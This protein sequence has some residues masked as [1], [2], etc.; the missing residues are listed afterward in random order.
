MRFLL[1]LFVCTFVTL[2]RANGPMDD[3]HKCDNTREA[4]EQCAAYLFDKDHD[5]RITA[6]EIDTVVPDLVSLPMT[7]GFNST[8]FM[9]CDI[10][11][12]GALTH[13][14]WVHPNATACLPT[15]NLLF[16]AC[17]VCVRNGFV[18]D[19]QDAQKKR[20]TPAYD[21]EGVVRAAMENA[22]KLRERQRLN[23]E[24]IIKNIKER[25]ERE[26]KIKAEQE[27]ET[28]REKTKVPLSNEKG[29]FN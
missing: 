25:T 21:Y 14:D 17:I 1:I 13:E 2:V 4:I 18:M 6:D 12:D 19:P 9:L 15:Q 24:E 16:V 27:A 28:R 8:L 26:A 29:R 10:D 7:E 22:E 11:E 20:G 5:G 3:M 23:Q